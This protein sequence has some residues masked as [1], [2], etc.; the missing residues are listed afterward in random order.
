M[1]MQSKEQQQLPLRREVVAYLRGQLVVD[2]TEPTDEASSATSA[3]LR[4][5][6]ERLTKDTERRTLFR[7]MAL[8]SGRK[9]SDKAATAWVFGRQCL[10]PALAEV[11][12]WCGLVSAI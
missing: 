11:G 8:E 3:A 7:R 1:P 12:Q 2:A 9:M 10:R 4:R 5:A 6:V